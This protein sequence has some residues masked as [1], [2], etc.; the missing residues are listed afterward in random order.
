MPTYYPQRVD[1]PFFYFMRMGCRIVFFRL[2]LNAKRKKNYYNF[3]WFYGIST[4]V[5]YLTLNPLYIFTWST[6]ERREIRNFPYP[7]VFKLT[8]RQRL[9]I[10]RGIRNVGKFFAAEVT[11]PGQNESQ[12]ILHSVTGL[13][14]KWV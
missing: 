9:T 12:E 2:I 1:I 3:V 13:I 10:K 6:T 8:G 7:S 4:I 11:N 14:K 5:G